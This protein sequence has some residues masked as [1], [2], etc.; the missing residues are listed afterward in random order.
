MCMLY[1]MLSHSKFMDCRPKLPIR[2]LC[3]EASF[4]GW[5]ISVPK[6]FA[7]SGFACL[8]RAFLAQL[9]FRSSLIM[10][11]PLFDKTNTVNSDHTHSMLFTHSNVTADGLE[12]FVRSGYY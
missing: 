11:S 1:S 5:F 6:P 7:P 2:A 8:L 4:C 12:Y 9:A 10:N 3:L